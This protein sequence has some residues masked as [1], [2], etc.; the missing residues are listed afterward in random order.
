LLRLRDS[1][2]LSPI[3]LRR[4]KKVSG[5]NKN[6]KNLAF[7]QSGQTESAN[8]LANTVLSILSKIGLYRNI[9]VLDVRKTVQTKPSNI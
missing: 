8:L 9:Y 1:T 4:R 7:I 5:C 2:N 3:Q 6:S